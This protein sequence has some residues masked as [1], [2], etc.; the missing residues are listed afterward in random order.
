MY[1]LNVLRHFAMSQENPEGARKGLHPARIIGLTLRDKR[2][3]M[4]VYSPRVELALKPCLLRSKRSERSL[5][6]A[7]HWFHA[8][9]L[10]KR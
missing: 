4:Q 10:R 2:V 8:D 9:L 6:V 5:K 7:V 3:I 1:E